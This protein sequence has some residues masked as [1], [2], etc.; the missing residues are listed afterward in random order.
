MFQVGETILSE[1]IALARFACD[2]SRCKG[3]CCVV[4]V[5]GAPIDERERV[6]LRRAWDLLR[7]EL[8]DEAVQAVEEKGLF[9]R[10]AKGKLELSC[11]GEGACVFAIENEQ[12][13]SICAIQQAWMEGRFHWEKPV[14]CH[15]YPIRLSRIGSVE[16][17]NFEYLPD[18]CGA[19]C[20]RGEKEGIWLSDFLRPALERRYGT[21]W[22]G[23][24]ER[25]CERIR[26]EG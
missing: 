20:E 21:S 9:Q 7:S 23:E 8:P 10:G 4:G 12:G 6:P 5:S 11:V 18:L 2:I 1:E 22:V 16:Y 14:S 26:R 25:E 13:A 19:G 15:L 24:F 3:A 17:A